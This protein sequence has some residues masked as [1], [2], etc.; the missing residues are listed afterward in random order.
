MPASC[1]DLRES[2][3]DRI[4][5]PSRGQNPRSPMAAP[6]KCPPRPAGESD[7]SDSAFRTCS[8]SAAGSRRHH[9]MSSIPLSAWPVRC[10]AAHGQIQPLT[11]PPHIM[12]L[13]SRPAAEPAQQPPLPQPVDVHDQHGLT[14]LG[15]RHYCDSD[16]KKP[17]PRTRAAPVPVAAYQIGGSRCWQSCRRLAGRPRLRVA[18]CLY[19]SAQRKCLPSSF[20]S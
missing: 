1:W 11:R 15:P 18:P 17:D 10:A 9:S 4:V 19:Q 16:S 6:H 3:S 7:S 12:N 20:F 13:S 8:Q 2:N 14:L 5:S